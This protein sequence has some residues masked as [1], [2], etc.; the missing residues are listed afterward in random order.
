MDGTVPEIKNKKCQLNYE[1]MII[2]MVNSI[3]D[4]WI[5]QQIYRYIKNI[6]KE[7]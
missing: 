6:I 4:S 3:D 7:G 5:L 2:E 1:K